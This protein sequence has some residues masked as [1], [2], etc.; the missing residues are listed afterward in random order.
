MNLAVG[1]AVSRDDA[2]IRRL[3]ASQPMPGRVRISFCR[4]PDFSLGCAVTGQDVR[5]LVARTEPDDEV[6]GVACRSIRRVFINGLEQRIGYLGQLR[7]H[8]RC[9]GRWLVSRGFTLLEELNR[10]DPVPVY[11]VSIVNG[12]R[13]AIGVLVDKPRKRF[14]ALREVAQY[15]TYAIRVGKSKGF[16]RRLEIITHGTVDQLDEIAEFLRAEGCRRQLSSVWSVDALRELEGLGLALDDLRIARR[17]GRIVG[18]LAL[19]DQSAYKQ[20]VIRGYTGWLKPVAAILPRP[21]TMLSSVYAA[22]VAVA[23]DDATVF[24]TL[25]REIYNLA[26]LRGYE[27]LLVGLDSRDP[28]NDAVRPYRHIAYPS[29]LYLASWSSGGSRHEPLDTR[30]VYVDI[31][32]L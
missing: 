31:A 16:D 32:T 15:I 14:P 29:R 26:S 12:N 1:Y 3:V 18:V 7:V 6:V 22:L 5:I 21:G 28:L 23:D 8:E 4:E 24:G 30:P 10:A 19:W 20:P 17:N 11:L 9:R 2:G 27:Y 25:L 13:D